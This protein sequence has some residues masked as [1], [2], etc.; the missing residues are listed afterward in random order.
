MPGHQADAAI[1]QEVGNYSWPQASALLRQNA[2][3]APVHCN[4]QHVFDAL[5]SVSCTKHDPLQN[6]AR[7]RTLGKRS[8][9]AL[10]VTTKN[11]LF[12]ESSCQCQ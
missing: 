6:Q 5:I 10:Q 8:E 3:H 9:L 11:D 4:H 7:V 1:L 2:E 12:A